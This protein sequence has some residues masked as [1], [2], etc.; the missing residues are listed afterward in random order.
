[1]S[2]TEYKSEDDD[3]G[4]FCQCCSP[5]AR[6]IGYFLTFAIG[7]IAFVIG[8]IKVI[9]GNVA[10]LIVGSLL[11]L[12]CPLWVKSPKKCLSEFKNV[13]KITSS[14]IFIIL[15]ILNI[16][17]ATVFNWGSFVRYLLGILLAISAIWYFL[18]YIPNA[19]K[20]CAECLKSCCRKSNE[21]S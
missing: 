17:V 9:G 15:L 8:I 21:A 1:M 7:V 19:Q 5:T 20:G 2:D 10:W 14:I 4:I 6:K 11:M 12:F 3:G 13:L 18:S 16:L